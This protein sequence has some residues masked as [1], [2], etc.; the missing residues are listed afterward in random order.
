MSQP[1]T[2]SA[3]R[4]AA[5][6]RL[7][8]QRGSLRRSVKTAV[9]NQTEINAEYFEPFVRRRE[10]AEPS[11]GDRVPTK[12]LKGFLENFKKQKRER[13]AAAKAS[14]ETA[15]AAAGVW[16]SL[17]DQAKDQ[18]FGQAFFRWLGGTAI[19]LG[20]SST[21]VEEL[22]RLHEEA[23]FRQRAL[24]AM[25]KLTNHEIEELEAQIQAKKSLT[26]GLA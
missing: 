2:L 6:E 5:L 1:S 14:D 8:A 10:V 17:L 11:Q 21:P 9:D 15:P 24:E 23:A 25:L 4:L 7:R 20:V 12:E 22:E 18:D 3:K 19:D 26:N 16:Q 13:K